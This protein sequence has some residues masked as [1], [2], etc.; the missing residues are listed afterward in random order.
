MRFFV[1]Q[2]KRRAET[3][4]QLHLY[5]Q[6]L[7]EIMLQIC[8]HSYTDTTFIHT[9]KYYI[10]T[11]ASTDCSNCNCTELQLLLFTITR[12]TFSLGRVHAVFAYLCPPS[13]PLRHPLFVLYTCLIIPPRSHLQLQLKRFDR[14]DW[15]IDWR[16]EAK[17]IKCQTMSL[18]VRD[19]SSPLP[20]LYFKLFIA[21]FSWCVFLLTVGRAAC[22]RG[23][24]DFSHIVCPFSA[25]L[26]LFF[27]R[28]SFASPLSRAGKAN[29]G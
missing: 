4:R 19:Q 18:S 11:H 7:L 14:F 13:Q 12:I 3:A 15:L 27:L 1:C 2:T 29:L 25:T 21:S 26:S 28:L 23:G 10:H 22:L 6:I 16:I 8:R 5:I 24:T 20:L 17:L 9:Y